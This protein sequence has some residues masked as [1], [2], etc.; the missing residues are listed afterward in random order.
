MSE[1]PKLTVAMEQ[2][3]ITVLLHTLQLGM[4]YLRNQMDDNDKTPDDLIQIKGLIVKL[5][6]IAH[7]FVDAIKEHRAS[8]VKMLEQLFRLDSDEQ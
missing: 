7:V 5:G 4:L 3:E 6:S 8:E 1:N 2:D